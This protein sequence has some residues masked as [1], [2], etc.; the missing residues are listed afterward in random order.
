MAAL[1]ALP[2]PAGHVLPGSGEARG[3][4]TMGFE[5]SLPEFL[6]FSHF[7][8]LDHF[9]GKTNSFGYL[10]WPIHSGSSLVNKGSLGMLSWTKVFQ[11]TWRMRFVG[12]TLVGTLALTGSFSKTIICFS[13]AKNGAEPEICFYYVPQMG[14]DNPGY[15]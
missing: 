3:R 11:P 15:E 1:L 14:Q 2:G 13:W 9:S 6:D 10:F 4:G 8:V 7:L 12:G 5:A